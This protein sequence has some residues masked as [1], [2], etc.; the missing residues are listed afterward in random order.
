MRV[1]VTNEE[2]LFSRALT[3]KHTCREQQ[4][5]LREV[6]FPM[7]YSDKAPRHFLVRKFSLK[8]RYVIFLL[9]L[10]VDGWIILEWISR[11]WDVVYGLDWAGPG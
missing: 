9:D 10:G 8:K 1:P 2:N 6:R 7:P 4:C 3:S 5:S 11:R